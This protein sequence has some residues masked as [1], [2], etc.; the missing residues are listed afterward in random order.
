MIF[1]NVRQR[2][3]PRIADAS[4]NLRSTDAKAAAMGCTANG[5]L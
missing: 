3:A 4:S 2:D 1:Q 5:R